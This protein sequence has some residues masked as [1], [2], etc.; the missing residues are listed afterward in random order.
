[1]EPT[2]T[3]TIR[4]IAAIRANRTRL[5]AKSNSFTN[6]VARKAISEAV[7]IFDALHNVPTPCDRHLAA[8]KANR[9]RLAIRASKFTNEIARKAIEDA[10]S[11]AA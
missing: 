10:L 5:A 6:E 9:T 11:Q 8:V 1:M 4:H 7:A 2:M 3:N